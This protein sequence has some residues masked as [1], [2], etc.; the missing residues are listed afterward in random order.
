MTTYG[1]GDPGQHWFRQ[2]LI[3]WWH[4]AIAWTNVDLSSARFWGHY[5]KKIWRYHSVKQDWNP[6]YIF[7]ITLRYPRGQWVK[8]AFIHSSTILKKACVLL[9]LKDVKKAYPSQLLF[10]DDVAYLLCM[11]LTI[12]GIHN[13]FTCLRMADRALLAGY[14]R[15]L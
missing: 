2:W 4:Q 9:I 12:S 3:A 15:I 10:I 14:P 7:K 1:I 11:L 6:N 8:H 5:H 13:V